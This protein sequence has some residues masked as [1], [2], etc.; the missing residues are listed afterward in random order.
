MD[1]IKIG[2]YITSKRKEKAYTQQKLAAMLS[3]SDK[4]ISKWE[5]GK[6]MLEVSLLLPLCKPLGISVNE[7][8]S[9]SDITEEGYKEKAENRMLSLIALASFLPI[10]SWA[11]IL[12]LI[13]AL[14]VAVL[15][16]ISGIVLD[17]QAGYYECQNCYTLFV[18]EIGSYVKGIHTFTRRRLACP[19]CHKVTM[20]RK[21][22]TK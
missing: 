17:R 19:H 9:G 4:A 12:I 6:G 13:A 5:R 18:P 22:I 3:V 15:G 20:A 2:V 21:R 1:Q 7:L 8:L 11:R 16:V 10:P 14:L